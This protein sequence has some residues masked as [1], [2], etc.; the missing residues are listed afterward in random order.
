MKLLSSGKAYLEALLILSN[1]KSTVRP[2]HLADFM[3]FSRPSI[4]NIVTNLSRKC[5]WEMWEDWSLHLAPIGRTVAERIYELHC[6]FW[7]RLLEV[8]VKPEIAECM[9]L[10]G[11]G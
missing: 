1:E 11:T 2:Y 3:G 6:F 5:L 8:G 10:K 7:D 9:M 4:S